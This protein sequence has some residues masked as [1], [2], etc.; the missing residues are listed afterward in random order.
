MKNPS[1]SF[2]LSPGSIFHRIMRTVWQLLTANPTPL[3]TSK[4]EEEP[5]P[6]ADAARGRVADVG[7]SWSASPLL[8]FLGGCAVCGPFLSVLCCLSALPLLLGTLDFCWH[9]DL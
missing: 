5:A 6:R 3:A 4:A 1:S 8:C 9:T 2:G 7:R